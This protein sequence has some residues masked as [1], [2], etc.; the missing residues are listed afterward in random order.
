[1]A[2]FDW[3]KLLTFLIHVTVLT[4]ALEIIGEGHLADH[5]IVMGAIF[6]SYYDLW[7]KKKR[8]IV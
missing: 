5:P 7:G 1:M 3:R 8:K 6:L 2:I 4:F